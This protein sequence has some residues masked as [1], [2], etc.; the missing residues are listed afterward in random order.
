MNKNK[1]AKTKVIPLLSETSLQLTVVAL[2]LNSQSL[3]YGISALL[4]MSISMHVN[5]F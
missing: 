1:T 4:E 2:Y 5:I 3:T